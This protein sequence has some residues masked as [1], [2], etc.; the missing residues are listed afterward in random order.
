MSPHPDPLF[1]EALETRLEQF[2]AEARSPKLTLARA[3]YLLCELVPGIRS[4]ASLHWQFV[5]EMRGRLQKLKRE[6]NVLARQIKLLREHVEED[7]SADWWKY[8]PLDEA[9]D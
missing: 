5:E 1:L 6:Q 7:R 8:G 2:L 3:R 9:E 4:L